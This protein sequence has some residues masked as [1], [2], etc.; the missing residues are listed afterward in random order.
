VPWSAVLLVGSSGDRLTDVG[1]VVPVCSDDVAEVGDVVLVVV[2]DPESP[3]PQPV[4]SEPAATATAS[5]KRAEFGSMP[6][7]VMSPVVTRRPLS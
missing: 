7:A 4:A 3:P 2:F 5:A 6:R 1:G